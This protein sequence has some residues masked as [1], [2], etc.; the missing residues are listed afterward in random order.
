MGVYYCAVD[1]GAK[2][3]IESP[4]DFSIKFPGIC[5]PH[6]PFSNMVVMMNSRGSDFKIINDAGG[7]DDLYY[8]DDLKDVTEEVYQKYLSYFPWAKEEIYE[9]K[10]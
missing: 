8:A 1:M 10:E 4:G 5:H 2:E 3:K 6:N 9:A 7:M